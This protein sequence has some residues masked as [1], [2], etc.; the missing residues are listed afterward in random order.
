MAAGCAVCAFA[1][2]SGVDALI[3]NDVNGLQVPQINAQA[4]TKTLQDLIGN[5]AKAA[6]LAESAREVR[7]RYE[8]SAVVPLWEAVL[9][10]GTSR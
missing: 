5:E 2:V 8:L 7:E 10:G 9:R 3:Q 4:L 1:E 6:R